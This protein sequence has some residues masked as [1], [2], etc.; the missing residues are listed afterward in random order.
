MNPTVLPITTA[1]VG[2]DHMEVTNRSV[3]K[4]SREV[5]DASLLTPQRLHAEL[6]VTGSTRLE[7]YLQG[8]LRDAT[9]SDAHKTHRYGQSDRG[10]LETLQSILGVLGHRSWIYR[11]G[12][13]REFWILETSAKFLTISFDGS[14][15]VENEAGLDYVRGYFDADGGMPRDPRA[16]LYVQYCQNNRKSLETVKSILASWGIESGRIH[17]PS[18]RVDPDYWRFFIRAN[19]HSRFFDLVSS[20]HPRK[21]AQI[22]ARTKI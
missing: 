20:W 10:W 9:R 17:N 1:Q 13:H 12:K 8:A 22:V 21:R 19:S 16:R 6:L 3:R 18:V 11:E 4:I 14:T 15:L 2:G 5:G 7:S